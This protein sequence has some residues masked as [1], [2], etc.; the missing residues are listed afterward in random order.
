MEQRILHG[1]IH[2]PLKNTKLKTELIDVDLV[3]G[4]LFPKAKPKQGLVTVLRLA[5][6]RMAL[7]PLYAKWWADQTSPK[8]V[9]F[10]V[11]LYLMQMFNV[12]VY[13]Y[14]MHRLDKEAEVCH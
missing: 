5:V 11:S 2:M 1:F 12:G 14:N 10:L 7:L 13:T 6:Q 9:T 8:I 3:R 4:S